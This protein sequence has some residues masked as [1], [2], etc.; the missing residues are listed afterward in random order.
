MGSRQESVSEQRD[1]ENLAKELDRD[2]L[3]EEPGTEN[4]MSRSTRN[5]VT[6]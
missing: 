4:R 2:N 1:L 3:A 5:F 6:G